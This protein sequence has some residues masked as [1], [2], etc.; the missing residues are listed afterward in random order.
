MEDLVVNPGFWKEKKV[1]ITGHTGFKG[2]WLSLWLHKLGSNL[3]GYSLEPPTEPNLFHIAGIESGIVSIFGDVR[4][5]ALLTASYEHHRP[6][7]VI[8]MAAQSLVRQ[9]YQDPVET[10]QTNVIGTVH[11]LEAARRCQFVKAVIIVT[12]DKCYEN[13][14]QSCLYKENEPLGGSDPYSSSKACAELATA[15]YRCSYF[16]HD[17]GSASLPAVASVRA[18]NV[19]GGGDWAPDRLVP[20]CIRAFT[21]RRSVQL[22][23]P[24]AVRPWQHVLEPLSGYLMLAERLCFHDAHDF[25]EAWN[26]GPDG[27]HGG[28]V[29]EV[30]QRI[31]T[32]WGNGSV[33]LLE[34]PNLPHEAGLLRLDSIKAISRLGWR[35]RWSL[36]RA[37]EETVSWYKAWHNGEDMRSYTLKQ[38]SIYEAGV[39]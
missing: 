12:S 25:S 32:L 19:I 15:A 1:L 29:D 17:K 33:T 6:D 3:V 11:V 39:S 28:T 16:G 20:D 10:Y 36:D 14:E 37:L 7:I 30:A 35:P 2:A 13:R 34:Q 9:S 18:G 38:I 5:L 23:Y 31:G 22:R 21:S 27:G 8:H 26:F 4:D 24:L